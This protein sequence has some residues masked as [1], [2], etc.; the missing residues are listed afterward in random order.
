MDAV[1]ADTDEWQRV[2]MGT[3]AGKNLGTEVDGLPG[4]H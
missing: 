4:W 3:L 1:Q 2:A